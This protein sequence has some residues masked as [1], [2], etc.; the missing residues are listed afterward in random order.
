MLCG[1]KYIINISTAMRKYF[2]YNA[3]NMSSFGFHANSA[4]ATNP[5]RASMTS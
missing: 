3:F 1:C 2:T 4:T 5:Q